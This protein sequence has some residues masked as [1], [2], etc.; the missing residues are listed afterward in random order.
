[1]RAKCIRLASSDP[2][3]FGRGGSETDRS[4]RLCLRHRRHCGGSTN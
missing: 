1:V 2:P 4:K 3:L